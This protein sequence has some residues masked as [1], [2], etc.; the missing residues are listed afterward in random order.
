MRILS[1]HELLR[2]LHSLISHSD[3]MIRDTLL[4]SLLLT[5]GCRISEITELKVSDINFEDEMITIL[6]KKKIKFNWL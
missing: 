4:F 6:K 2:F 1:R 5:T 3:N